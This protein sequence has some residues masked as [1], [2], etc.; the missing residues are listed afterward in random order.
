MNKAKVTM[1]IV[2]MLVVLSA[3]GGAVIFNAHMVYAS[4]Q[5]HQNNI[6]NH[7]TDSFNGSCQLAQQINNSCNPPKK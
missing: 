2:A 4:T 7:A 5:F 6:G 3:V 1:T